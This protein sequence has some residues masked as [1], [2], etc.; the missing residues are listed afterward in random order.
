MKFMAKTYMNTA[1]FRDLSLARSQGTLV[2]TPLAGFA[3]S[4]SRRIKY[5]QYAFMS[6]LNYVFLVVAIGVLIYGIVSFWK[7]RAKVKRTPDMED[8]NKNLVFA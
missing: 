8:A 3:G 1:T 7:A 2:D 5:I 6:F 4:N